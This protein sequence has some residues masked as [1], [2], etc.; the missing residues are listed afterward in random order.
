[1]HTE[2][3]AKRLWCPMARTS[4]SSLEDAHVNRLQGPE[5]DTC[6]GSRC[7]MWRWDMDWSSSVQE[8][9]GGDLVLRLKRRD[10]EP[11]RGFCGLGGRPP[12]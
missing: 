7:A 5:E 9:E 8:G 12:A 6:I 3:Q 1:M 2:E 11:Q 4:Y 10:G